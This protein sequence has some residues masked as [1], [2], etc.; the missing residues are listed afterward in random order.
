[1]IQTARY[2]QSTQQRPTLENQN[3]LLVRISSV[4]Q[5]SKKR[6]LK[7]A[8]VDLR[9]ALVDAPLPLWAWLSSQHVAELFM[10]QL[11]SIEGKEPSTGPGLGLSSHAE[12]AALRDAADRG[13]CLRRPDGS[14][15]T[16]AVRRGVGAD[17]LPLPRQPPV[18][19]HEHQGCREVLHLLPGA[20][21]EWHPLLVVLPDEGV[22]G[23]KSR[24][25][26]TSDQPAKSEMTNQKLPAP[27]WNCTSA[28]GETH[29]LNHSPITLG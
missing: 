4:S 6:L 22:D 23:V 14:T 3:V 17:D 5:R 19:T 24:E 16:V 18:C 27:S 15:D 28:Q 29:S 9:E 20:L 1:M 25:T 8:R 13:D 10:A 7:Q 2:L 11:L 12:S 26:I 21:P